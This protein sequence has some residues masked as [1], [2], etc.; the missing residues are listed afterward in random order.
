[1]GVDIGWRFIPQLLLLCCSTH[2][3]GAQKP[4]RMRLFFGEVFLCSPLI[5]PYARLE[6]VTKSVTKWQTSAALGMDTKSGYSLV[7]RRGVA[8]FG[9]RIAEWSPQAFMTNYLI[10]LELMC[11]SLHLLV[12]GV[13]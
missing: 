8:F 11:S 7:R 4:S 10:G 5:L 2:R 6:I 1:V 3:P 12:R 13:G 9:E